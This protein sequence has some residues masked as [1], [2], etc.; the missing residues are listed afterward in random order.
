M[1][2]NT[3]FWVIVWAAAVIICMIIIYVIPSIAGVFDR[4]YV[5]EYGSVEVSDDVDAFIIRDESVYTAPAAGEVNRLVKEG[6]LVK[7][8][9]RI[10]EITGTGRSQ[11]TN[12]SKSVLESLGKK[13]YTA[14]GGKTDVAGYVS[15]Y[16]DGAEGK[17][18][19]SRA[20]KLSQDKL[21]SYS[22]VSVNQFG[23]GR[24]AK[25]EPV[26]KITTNGDWLVVFYVDKGSSGHF[27]AGNQV[28]M[29]F[30]G[31]DNDVIGTVRSVKKQS[32]SYRVMIDSNMMF[33]SMLNKRKASITVTSASADGIVI[34]TSSLVKKNGQQGV[35]V[36]N[37][38]GKLVFTPVMIK[39]DN[40]TEAAVYQDLYMDDQGN[41]HNTMTVYDEVL[42][43]PSDS[44]VKNAT[45]LK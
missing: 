15:Y 42:K 5:A 40:G 2:K 31:Q 16:I 12:T 17:L 37:K 28:T 1:K 41:F 20:D 29:T 9:S 27:K 43:D 3:R 36:K 23:K 26:F 34:K 39:A 24:V 22:S 33:K 6:Q 18:T 19:T 44:D 25:G 8:G 35:I 4:T 7:A 32:G 21:R 11:K 30:P 13:S 45:V 14:E 38:V 10:V